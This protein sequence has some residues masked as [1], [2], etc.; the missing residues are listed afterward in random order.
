LPSIR[1]K[2]S[3]WP[4]GLTIRLD[5]KRSPALAGASS[6][7][8]S[9]RTKKPRFARILWKMLDSRQEKPNTHYDLSDA[10]D[11]PLRENHPQAVPFVSS[12]R[13]V[14]TG[15]ARR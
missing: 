9:T 10:R 2:S 4:S 6:L 5:V 12:R 8:A 3:R 14:I 11:Y 15:P 1:A 7:G 13:A